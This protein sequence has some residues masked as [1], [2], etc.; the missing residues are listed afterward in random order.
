[1]VGQFGEG[2]GDVFILAMSGKI[3]MEDIL[4]VFTFRWA[5]FDF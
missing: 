1:M 2:L 4:P 5:G 3:D